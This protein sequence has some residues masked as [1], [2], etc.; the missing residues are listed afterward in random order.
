MIPHLEP[1]EARLSPTAITN[2]GGPVLA[3]PQ[4]ND[5]FVSLA[6]PPMDQLAQV[7]T[8]QY[9]A[10]LAP[11]GVGEGALHSSITVPNP[12]PLSNA[13]VQQMLAAEITAGVLPAP[14]GN[15]LYMLYLPQQVTD[16]WAQQD[17]GYH[18]AF[19][20]NGL[21]VPYAVIPAQP[22]ESIPASHEFAETVTDPI[23]GTG[24]F[25]ANTGE[26]ICD[27]YN[28]QT[29]HLDGFPVT[30]VAAPDGTPLVGPNLSEQA[31]LAALPVEEFFALAWSY[32]AWVDPLFA[33]YAHAAVETLQANPM[34]G[35]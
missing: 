9:A 7:L 22:N 28:W 26:E 4:V 6:M 11:Y 14:D 16:G 15:Q 23:V 35:F 17:S 13:G 34:Y 5:V 8:T 19:T 1:L 2:H 30:I 20:W 25:G 31:A 27:L 21:W 10:I 33:P 18:S 3:N 12:G 32:I 24:W 29:F